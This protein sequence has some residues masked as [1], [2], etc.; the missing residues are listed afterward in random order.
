MND[1]C[2]NKMLVEKL[3]K[4]LYLFLFTFLFLLKPEFESIMDKKQLMLYS[5]FFLFSVAIHFF[6]LRKE[7]NWFRL[8]VLFILGFGIVHFQWP[9]MLAFSGIEPE[10][11]SRAFSNFQYI[12]YGILFRNKIRM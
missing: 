10:W 7:K 12:N 1:G 2:N 9:I 8:D 11:F 4:Y 5:S 6:Q 3:S